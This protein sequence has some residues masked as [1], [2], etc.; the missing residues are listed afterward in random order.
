MSSDRYIDFANSDIGRRLIAPLACQ[1]R[2]D[3]NA[4]KPGVCAR[5]KA[6]C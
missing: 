5:S 4:G 2:H 6:L 3:W 1:P